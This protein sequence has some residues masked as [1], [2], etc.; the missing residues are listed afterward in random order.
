MTTRYIT[1]YTVRTEWDADMPTEETGFGPDWKR[2]SRTLDERVA[3]LTGHV[4]RRQPR[5]APRV[6]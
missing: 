3:L 4:H 5:A 1:E 6:R 2:A